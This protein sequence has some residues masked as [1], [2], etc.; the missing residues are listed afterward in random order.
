MWIQLPG[1]EPSD[2]LN[3]GEVY[4][5]STTVRARR[6]GAAGTALFHADTNIVLVSIQERA[7]EIRKEQPFDMPCAAD[8]PAARRPQKIPT[9]V[10]DAAAFY[11]RDLHLRLQPA[12]PKGC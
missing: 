4:T 1:R 11:D 7:L 5:L 6:K 2:G 10:V 3:D 9:Y 8:E 12:Y